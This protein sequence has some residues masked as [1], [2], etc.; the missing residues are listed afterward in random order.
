MVGAAGDGWIDRW[1]F[2]ARG[3]AVDGVWRAGQQVVSGGRHVAR[4]GIAAR[5]RDTLARLLA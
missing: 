2:A 4:D 1:V 5:Y 3:G